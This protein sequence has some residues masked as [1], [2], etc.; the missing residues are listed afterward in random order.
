MRMALF[1]LACVFG[2]SACGSQ[3]ADGG[4]ANGSHEDRDL[5]LARAIAKDAVTAEEADVSSATFV[6]RSGTVTESNV[7]HSCT[8]GRLIEVKLIGDFPHIVTTGHPVR[9]GQDGDFTVTALDITADAADGKV[10][11]KGVQTGVVEPASG[12]VEIPLG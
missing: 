6:V 10:C 2:L 1:G 5:T 9:V 12:A 7:G 4:P 8:S 3:P 11:L